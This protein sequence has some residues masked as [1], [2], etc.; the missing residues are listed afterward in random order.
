[1]YL[2]SGPPRSITFALKIF[3]HCTTATVGLVE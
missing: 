1:M 3:I 2:R